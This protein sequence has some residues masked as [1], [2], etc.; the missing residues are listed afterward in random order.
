AGSGQRGDDRRSRRARRGG[1]ADGG[2][3]RRRVYRSERRPRPRARHV[4]VWQGERSAG[5]LDGDARRRLPRELHARGSGRVRHPRRGRPRP[6]GFGRRRDARARVGGR[7]GVLRRRDA[8]AAAQ[9]HRRG[10]RRPLLHAGQRGG[11]ARSGQLHRTRRDRRRRTRAVGHAGAADGA[12][13]AGRD[14]VG[15]PAGASACMTRLTTKTRKHENTKRVSCKTSFSCFRAFVLSW[16]MVLA[17]GGSAAAQDSHLLVITG[18]G[19][20]D[21]HTKTFHTWATAMIDAAKKKDGLADANIIYLS[22]KPELDS[23]RIQG[24]STRENV[25]KAF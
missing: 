17:L 20:D 18:V 21:E 5:R 15:L 14:G 1:E 19:G 13:R 25:Q 12:R 24:K 9:A 7:R 23:K 6:E 3:A 10:N 22:E 8:R 11:A 4:A 16:L 2:S